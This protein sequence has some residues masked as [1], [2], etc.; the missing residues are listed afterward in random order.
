MAGIT[1][2]SDLALLV[3]DHEE[4]RFLHPKEL[5][6]LMRRR[7]LFD[8]RNFLDHDLWRASGFE[9]DVL[10]AGID[11]TSEVKLVTLG[12]Q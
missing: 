8:T 1:R 6:K 4:F 10:G 7:L 12:A 11:K 5:G 2:A 9:V 3:A